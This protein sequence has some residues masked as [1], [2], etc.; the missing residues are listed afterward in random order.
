MAPNPYQQRKLGGSHCYEHRRVAAEK[1]GR[2]LKPGEVVHHE[3]DDPRNN[4]PDNVRVFASQ[5]EHMV[6][7]H[8]LR[9]EEVQPH[10]FDIET[11][12]ELK[13]LERKKEVP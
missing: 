8:Y 6:Y 7:H 2:P 12:L 3:D 5:T 1:L 13:R 11:W 10:L 4:E 9:R